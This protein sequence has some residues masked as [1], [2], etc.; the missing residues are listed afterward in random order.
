MNVN[1]DIQKEDPKGYEVFTVKY[2]MKHMRILFLAM[3]L[4]TL[5][6]PKHDSY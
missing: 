5:I 3:L 1:G 6:N 4:D 2:F